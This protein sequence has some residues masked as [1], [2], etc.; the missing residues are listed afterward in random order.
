M[1]IWQDTLRNHGG[2]VE[3]VMLPE[4]GIYGN[5]HFPFSD[6]N[7]LEVADLLYKYLEDKKLN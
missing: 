6:L 5:T 2:D 4:A 3:I 1:K 7:N